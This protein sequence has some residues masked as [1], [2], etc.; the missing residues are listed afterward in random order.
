MKIIE[1]TD[2]KIL[3]E[4]KWE[5][6]GKKFKCIFIK[7]G[8]HCKPYVNVFM[9]NYTTANGIVIEKEI[10]NVSEKNLS[11][12]EIFGLKVIVREEPK[13]TIKERYFL[14]CINEDADETYIARDEDG[15]IYCFLKLPKI[16]NDYWSRNSDNGIYCFRIFET[17]FSFI[18]WESQKAWSK[19]ELM[20]LEVVE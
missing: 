18:T 8:L 1:I 19:E 15:G 12:L 20:K 17:L 11:E 10:I 4:K 9:L 7:G 2:L 14:E 3:D 16:M 13:L 6:Q 5:Y